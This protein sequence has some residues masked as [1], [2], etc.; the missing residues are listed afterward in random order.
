MR[1]GEAMSRLAITF[2]TLLIV[3]LWGGHPASAYVWKCQ[4]PQG[5]VWT[6]EPNPSDNCQEY[7]PQYNPS[8]APPD[9]SP[10]SGSVV[11]PVPIPV[12]AIPYVAPYVYPPYYGYYGPPAV[13]IRPPF[14]GYPHG[15]FYGGHW[16]GGHRHWR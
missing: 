2:C 3:M 10:V 6:N 1:G 5:D 11:V 8:A 14:F 4:T 9:A 15:R 16:G 7:D 13:I 12:P